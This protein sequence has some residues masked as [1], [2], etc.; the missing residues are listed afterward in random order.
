MGKCLP[1]SSRQLSFV[2]TPDMLT[3]TIGRQHQKSLFEALLSTDRD[4]LNF[5][6]R[7][8]LQIDPYDDG[9]LRVTNMSQNIALAGTLILQRGQAARIGPGD[10]LSFAAQVEMIRGLHA[11]PSTPSSASAVGTIKQDAGTLSEG[12]DRVS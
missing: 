6:S 10:T 12:V 5:V 9:G 1:V 11:S 7:N 4:L 3:I 8:H 2:L